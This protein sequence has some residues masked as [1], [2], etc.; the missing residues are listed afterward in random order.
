MKDYGH[1]IEKEIV[2]GEGT[3]IIPK[4]MSLHDCYVV[5][6]NGLPFNQII[7]EEN[8]L[9]D[10]CFFILP[11]TNID[12]SILVNL[13]GQ[14]ANISI[15]AAYICGNTELINFKTEIIHRVPNCY[16]S[17]IFNGVAGGS[18]K[19]NFDGKIVVAPDAQQTQAFQ[20]NKNILLDPK[21]K[22]NTKPQLEIYADDVKCSHGATIGKLDEDE[23]FYML[24]RGI[25][26][27]D[28]KILQMISFLSPII[29]HISD[30]SESK[31]VKKQLTTAI[32][33]II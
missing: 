23:Q 10:I 9:A 6:K 20:L 19:I 14:G 16:S 8:S 28:A 30:E 3:M 22:I 26:M 11:N 33:Q 12:I 17:Q 24:S 7:L 4:G 29:E 18:A 27:K 25:P 13:I 5:D 2:T 21:A 1:Y 15:S 31:K 32:K